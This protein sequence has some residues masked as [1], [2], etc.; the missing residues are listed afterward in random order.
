MAG[1]GKTAIYPLQI[2]VNYWELKPARLAAKLNL[3][4]NQGVTHVATFVPWQ[5]AENDISH[6]LAKFLQLIA[7]RKMSATLIVSP[8][9]GAHA[10]YAGLPK[11][12]AKNSEIQARNRDEQ[13]AIVALPPR[14]F[15]LPSLHAKTFVT[16][17][18]SFLTKLDQMIGEMARANPELLE[19]LQIVLTGSFFKYYRP[20][21]GSQ[22]SAFR[23]QNGDRSN[24][25]ELAFRT[26]L[27][28][29]AN[30]REFLTMKDKLRSKEFE[31]V[32]R[33]RF[34]NH[35][36]EVFRIRQAQFFRKRSLGV[37]V[38]QAE[39][40][41]P[42]AD[43]SL[44]YS[45]VFQLTSR[46][47]ADFPALDRMIS[48]AAT[49]QSMVGEARAAP[50]LHW[51]GFGPFTRLTDSEKQFLILKSLLLLGG[52]GGGVVLDEAEWYSLS[53]PFRKRAE[54]FAQTLL[55]KELELE[56]KAFCLT[57]HLWSDGKTGVP[58]AS[59]AKAG[60][61]AS[62][63]WPE[64]R[65]TL[66]TQARLIA[67]PEAAAWE[68][69]AK[70]LFV[71]PNVLLTLET[72]RK[73]ATWVEGGRVLVFSKHQPMTSEVR[74]EFDAAF[75]SRQKIDMNLGTRYLI[76]A[77]GEGKIVVFEPTTHASEWKQ[78]VASMLSLSQATPEMGVSDPR[79]D[80]VCLKR[81][82]QSGSGRAGVFIF[83]ATRTSIAAEVR[84]ENEVTVADLSAVLSRETARAPQEPDDD[85]NA[86]S[87]RFELE[88]PPCGVLPISVAGLGEVG[89][90]K[91][92]AGNLSGLT[93]KAAD[94]A[95]NSELSGFQMGDD[96]S[97]V[98]K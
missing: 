83:N 82:L 80:L 29:Y 90:E 84:F 40:F 17:Y 75:K 79:I 15:A 91:R 65:L 49:R 16:R 37:D 8:E 30:L 43:P 50:M 76:H 58:S 35:A 64:L 98:F 33:A 85:Q 94:E 12:L 14:I 74:A 51:T 78:F 21:S 66:D 45:N 19:S 7:D 3:L 69:E 97:D 41:T 36:E 32:F 67:S 81:G 39:L 93:S 77:A 18:H 63:F 95:A 89:R 46:G 44:T 73:L 27:D 70:I 6:S 87:N 2:L 11:D 34:Q 62:V 22:L 52:R 48:E 96:F 28:Q 61:G 42:E 71:E 31:P 10:L 54:L 55:S 20:A 88:A 24:S 47:M 92:I 38:A 1:P 9:V 59:E 72:W 25:A 53:A 4:L 23:G 5:T 13:A 56:T 60:A 57:G 68:D 86:E 26:E